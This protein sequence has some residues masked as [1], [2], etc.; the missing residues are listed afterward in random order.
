MRLKEKCV[1]CVNNMFCFIDC[2]NNALNYKIRR[3]R[4]IECSDN[5]DIMINLLDSI[6]CVQSTYYDII[7]Y[8]PLWYTKRVFYALW[9]LWL[10]VLSICN[11]SMTNMLLNYL[12]IL[13]RTKYNKY[14]NVLYS[15]FTATRYTI[16]FSF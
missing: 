8:S 16:Y 4:A 2:C 3:K 12:P 13:N 11:V 6:V 14:F 10:V 7:S 5:C 15:Y 1:L 9:K